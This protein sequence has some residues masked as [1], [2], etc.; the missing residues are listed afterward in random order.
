MEQTNRKEPQGFGEHT[1]K[2]PSEN[3]H[4]QGWGLNE[5]ERR[6][7]A[8]QGRGSQGGTDYDYGARDFG[9]NPVDTSSAEPRTDGKTRPAGRVS[10]SEKD[11]RTSTRRG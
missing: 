10:G 5:E 4:E 3:A 7:L 9:D 11:Q 6:R 1:R 8:E 2:A